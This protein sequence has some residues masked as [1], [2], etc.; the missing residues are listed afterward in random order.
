MSNR[1]P[2]FL[3]VLMPVISIGLHGLFSAC[4]LKEITPFNMF[5][6]GTPMNGFV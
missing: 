5:I 2:I 4:T 3:I 6:V 1:H